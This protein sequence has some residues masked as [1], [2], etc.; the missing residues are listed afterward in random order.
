MFHYSIMSLLISDTL[1][2]TDVSFEKRLKGYASLRFSKKKKTI[3]F[4]RLDKLVV[5][6]EIFLTLNHYKIRIISEFIEIR[7]E[8]ARESGVDAD[9]VLFYSYGFFTKLFF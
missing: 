6:L 2:S 4:F 8:R 1:I 7:S 3:F 9:A 5:L